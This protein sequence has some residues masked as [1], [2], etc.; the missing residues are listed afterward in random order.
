MHRGQ[1]RVGRFLTRHIGRPGDCE[2]PRDNSPLGGRCR[3]PDLVPHGRRYRRCQR[4]CMSHARVRQQPGSMAVQ[5][6]EGGALLPAPRLLDVLKAG[7]L[8]SGAP[9]VT[10]T[11]PKARRTDGRPG[12]CRGSTNRGSLGLKTA[13]G[14]AHRRLLGRLSKLDEPNAK[15]SEIAEDWRTEGCSG[16]WRESTFHGV[17]AGFPQGFHRVSTGFPQGF[18]RVSTGFPRGSHRVSTGFPRGF[19]RVS[20]DSAEGQ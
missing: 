19:H 11:L 6:P 18:R 4:R 20:T 17:S 14:S 12:A 1:G 16:A 5:G 13:E 3:H 10:R 9:L 8:V 7:T 15:G 2:H